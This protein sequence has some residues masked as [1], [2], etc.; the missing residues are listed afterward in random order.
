MWANTKEHFPP[1][2]A[3]PRGVILPCCKE[4]NVLV[5]TSNPFDFEK[6]V[7]LV[8]N[9]LKRR[10]RKVLEMPVWSE[11]DLEDTGFAIRGSIEEWQN[12]RRIAKSRLAWNAMSYLASIDHHNAFARFLAD[13]G[14]ITE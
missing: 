3:T 2:S 8:K 4:C 1:A 12:E 13:Y 14:S 5:G 7:D 6:R 11:D 10:Y 9:K